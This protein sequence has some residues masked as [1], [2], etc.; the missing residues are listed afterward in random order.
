MKS[1]NKTTQ[2]AH[3][4]HSEMKHRGRQYFSHGRPAM[5]IEARR[6]LELGMAQIFRCLGKAQHRQHE[7]S[8]GVPEAVRVKVLAIDPRAGALDERIDRVP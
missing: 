5:E 2:G 7:G 6:R 1:M 3:S 8:R 4:L